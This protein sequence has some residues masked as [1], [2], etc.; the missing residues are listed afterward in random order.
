MD[1]TNSSSPF[2]DETMT[3]FEDETMAATALCVSTVV[4]AISIIVCCLGAASPSPARDK[5]TRVIA[6]FV[7]TNFPCLVMNCVLL[8]LPTAV[9]EESEDI[10][11]V[12]ED[13]LFHAVYVAFILLL[14]W[15]TRLFQSVFN[16]FAHYISL[17]KFGL[18]AIWV[19]TALHIGL[20][21][22][23]ILQGYEEVI[24]HDLLEILT[25]LV[26]L[27]VLLVA[28]FVFLDTIRRSI[29][30]KAQR[31]ILKTLVTSLFL[32]VFSVLRV[33]FWVSFEDI[34]DVLIFLTIYNTFL[35]VAACIFLNM[36]PF[37]WMQVEDTKSLRK[38]TS[39]WI[40]S[41]SSM[42]STESLPHAIDL[43]AATE[44]DAVEEAAGAG[45]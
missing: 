33:Y 23:F 14:D 7:F 18:V 22:K 1:S 17:F 27:V 10:L 32:V 19:S 12:F 34:V 26:D 40:S 39:S 24:W 15:R 4:Y 42:S 5:R 9:R 6:T 2:D 30:V 8:G 44:V 38:M 16:R 29:R 20:D 21:I 45:K 36:R 11:H 41:R 37:F 31:A 13:L 25:T 3:L 35:L 28:N 43:P